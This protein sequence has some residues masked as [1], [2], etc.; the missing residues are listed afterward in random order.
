MA[1]VGEIPMIN[2]SNKGIQDILKNSKTI[3]IVGLSSDPNKPSNYVAQFLKEHG[4]TIVPVNPTK[5]ELLGEKCYPSLSDI[6]FD[7]DVADVFRRPEDIPLVADDAINKGV[8]V[9]WMQEGIANNDAADKLRNAGISVVMD[10]CIM[11]EYK[12]QM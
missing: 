4:Y 11:K 5:N 6:P 8:K 1:N 9:F 12:A 2:A 3:A 10:K 7:I